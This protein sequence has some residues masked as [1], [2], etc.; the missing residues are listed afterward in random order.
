MTDKVIKWVPFV[1]S[2]SIDK[3]VEIQLFAKQNGFPFKLGLDL[4]NGQIIMSTSEA[5]AEIAKKL[6]VE[7]YK[8]R[9][10]PYVR[11]M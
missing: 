5:F 2:R 4:E 9:N 3:A 6:V 10:R 1:S 11:D 8:R 7:E